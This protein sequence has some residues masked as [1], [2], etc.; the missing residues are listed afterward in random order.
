MKLVKKIAYGQLI[1][2]LLLPFHL[3]GLNLITPRSLSRARR[4]KTD[5]SGTRR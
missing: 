2:F 3:L 1:F 5:C 4:K